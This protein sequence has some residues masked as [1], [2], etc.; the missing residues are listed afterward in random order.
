[1]SIDRRKFIQN[2][3]LASSGVAI[4]G[5]LSSCKEI[6]NS[7]VEKKSLYQPMTD[8]IQFITKDE[9]LDRIEKARQLMGVNGMGSKPIN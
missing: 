9:R 7:K 3:I 4:T 1:M 6:D 2:T 8:G 5:S